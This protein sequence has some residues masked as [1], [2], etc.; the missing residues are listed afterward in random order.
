MSCAKPPLYPT[1]HSQ[2]ASGPLRLFYFSRQ[3]KRSEGAP[4]A[5]DN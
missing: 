1:N 4:H 5:R 3:V 2:K